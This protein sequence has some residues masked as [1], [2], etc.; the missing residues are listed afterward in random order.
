M[1]CGFIT[2]AHNTHEDYLRMAYGLA[3]SLRASQ[4]GPNGLTVLVPP[5]A[6]VPM[7]YQEVFDKVVEFP[8][9]DDSKNASWKIHN[10]WKAIHASPYEHTILLDADML[11]TVDVSKWW[12][13][14][15][16]RQVW[17]CTRPQTYRG[18]QIDP[19]PYRK[20]FIENDLPPVYTALTYFDKSPFSFHLFDAFRLVTREWSTFR[21]NYFQAPI[22]EKVSGD[23]AF[24]TAVKLLEVEDKVTWDQQEFFSFVHMK[25]KCQ[26]FKYANRMS[27]D[28]TRH[29]R[30]YLNPSLDLTIGVFKQTKP[31]HYVQKHFLTDDMLRMLEN[32]A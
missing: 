8:W 32:A 22:P 29:L 18:E 5:G 3:L 4:S 23:L 6:D 7:H 15:K 16:R 9:G 10:K 1:S 14:L 17:S 13:L 2:V 26:G 11:F 30:S 24:A 25:T 21:P 12:P 19:T 20:A 27:E 31:F 28:W